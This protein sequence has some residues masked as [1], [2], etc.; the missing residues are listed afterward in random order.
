MS[1]ST[2]DQIKFLKKL[3]KFLMSDSNY[4][5]ILLDN[6]MSIYSILKKIKKL[7]YI[8]K[9]SKSKVN[10]NKL[11]KKA[12]K[13]IL[14]QNNIL[15]IEYAIF[16]M[17]TYVENDNIPNNPENYISPLYLHDLIYDFLEVVE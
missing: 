10:T 7:E 17:I 2:Y 1:L 9:I 8:Q 5:E 6:D 14:E 13:K 15:Q 16:D 4:K 12:E 11:L 3:I